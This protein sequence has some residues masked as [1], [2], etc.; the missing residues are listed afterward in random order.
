MSY[1]LGIDTSSIELGIGL[2]KDGD[3]VMGVSRYFRNSHAEHITQCLD[4]F[5]KTNKI[6]ASDI[7]HA[8][9]AVG[10]GSFTGLRIGI[11][12]IKGFFFRRNAQVVAV[13]SLESMAGSLHVADGN[14]VAASDA[15]NN[16]IFWA[17]FHVRNGVVTRLTNDEL[18]L[19]NTFSAAIAESD[20][21]ITDTL[22]YAKSTSFGFLDNR[23]NTFAVEKFPMQRGLACA[24]A[25]SIEKDGSL[26]WQSVDTIQPLYLNTSSVERK[27]SQTF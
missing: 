10:P 13:S 6:S 11:A 27:H 9:I 8:G 2:Y 4:F 14:V 22:G 19:S 1:F 24:R 3:P 20:F 12:F 15:R 17:R 25:A 23:P 21:I 18:C 26:R 16:E 5:L 7:L